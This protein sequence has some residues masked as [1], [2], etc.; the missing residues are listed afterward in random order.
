MFCLDVSGIYERRAE[1]CAWLHCIDMVCIRFGSPGVFA[2]ALLQQLLYP[3]H[4]KKF[5]H[6]SRKLV[7][8]VLVFSLEL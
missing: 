3:N 8:T 4:E 5:R 1:A 2:T 6:V 7:G